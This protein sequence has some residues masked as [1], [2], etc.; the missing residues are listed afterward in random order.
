MAVGGESIDRNMDKIKRELGVVFQNS[1]LDRVLS[2]QDNLMN[3]A[4]LYGITGAAFR[5]RLD[6]LMELLDFRGLLK[7]DGRQAVRR[8]AQADRHC[9]GALT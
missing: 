5:R 2:V 4:A 1:A 8:A 3:R 9:P 6:E 7:A